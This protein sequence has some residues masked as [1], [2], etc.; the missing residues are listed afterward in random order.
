VFGVICVGSGTDRDVQTE[1]GPNPRLTHNLPGWLLRELGNLQAF[2][3]GTIS[4]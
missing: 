1:G 4:P 2:T 3:S